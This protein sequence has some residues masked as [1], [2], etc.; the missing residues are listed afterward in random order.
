MVR[1]NNYSVIVGT[2]GSG[3]TTQVPQMILEE[4]IVKGQGSST[5]IFCTQP[6]CIAAQ[7]IAAH[8]AAERHEDIQD[9]V[10][11]Q[12]RD[13]AKFPREPGP[14][15]FCTTDILLARL[16]YFLD[17]TMDHISHIIIDEVHER[18][19]DIDTLLMTLKKVVKYR[20]RKNQRVPKIV[21]M[22]AILDVKLFSEYFSQVK[23]DGTKQPCPS[24]NVQGRSFPVQ[25]FL[26]EDITKSMSSRLLNIVTSKDGLRNELYT[27]KYLRKE[28]DLLGRSASAVSGQQ[29]SG[30]ETTETEPFSLKIP[31]LLAA[32]TI[33]H[34]V[35]STRGGAILVFYLESARLLKLGI[36]WNSPAYWIHFNAKFT[37]F[38]PASRGQ[39]TMY[40]RPQDTASGRLFLQPTLQKLL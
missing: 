18:D 4:A 39:S 5:E 22:S 15:T 24:T 32:A 2:T 34:V 29:S 17:E 3:K 9:T 37:S 19:I 28:T 16:R 10:G 8:V 33:T 30:N 36:F 20:K 27:Y 11:Y 6:R 21:L 23:S 26:L 13:D 7:S 35:E 12:V 14:I 1:N 25:E 38:T 31:T 40:L